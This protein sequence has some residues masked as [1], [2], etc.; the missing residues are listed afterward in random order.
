MAVKP[1]N[2]NRF[3]EPPQDD[4]V[5]EDAEIRP[6]SLGEDVTSTGASE[7][8]K[9]RRKHEDRL[10]E[11]DGVEGVS[12]ETGDLGEDVVVVFVRDESVVERVPKTLDGV[13]V[14]TEVTGEFDALESSSQYEPREEE[15]P[16]PPAPRPAGRKAVKRSSGTDPTA[17]A[18]AGRAGTKRKSPSKGAAS[19]AKP[20]ETKAPAKKAATGKKKASAPRS[21]PAKGT[22]RKSRA[23]PGSSKPR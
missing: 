15:L 21:G 18:P 12:V 1:N 5:E 3:D 2:Q 11:I 14:Q 6:F 23:K 19:E 4:S 7:A 17:R 9:A 20:T 22:A 10:I 8:E 13:P 16:A